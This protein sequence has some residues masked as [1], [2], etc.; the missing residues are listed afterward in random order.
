MRTFISSL[1][2]RRLA[3]GPSCG[4][5]CFLRCLLYNSSMGRPS[6]KISVVCETCGSTVLRSPSRQAQFCSKACYFTSKVKRIAA[7]F[8]SKVNKDGPIPPHCP[9]LGPCWLWTAAVLKGIGYGAFNLNGQV[10]GAHQ[11]SLWLSNGQGEFSTEYS[12]HRCD[13]R[14]CVNP[15][16]LFHGSQADNIRDAVQKGRMPKGE[17]IHCSKLTEANVLEIFHSREHQETTA[18]RFGIIRQTV[19]D[20]RRGR[21]WAW[22]TSSRPSPLQVSVLAVDEH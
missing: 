8:W 10:K 4:A 12:L 2:C 5:C 20:I 22:L 13:N 6:T 16:H 14:L 15:T 17:A 9:E 21:R 3:S 19:S 11:V 7:R 1:P 18:A